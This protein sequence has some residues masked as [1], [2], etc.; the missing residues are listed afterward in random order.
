LRREDVSRTRGEDD[1]SG[2]P[3]SSRNAHPRSSR[4]CNRI[5]AA[6]ASSGSLVFVVATVVAGVKWS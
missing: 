2:E 4:V 3:A 6:V 1:L 5:A